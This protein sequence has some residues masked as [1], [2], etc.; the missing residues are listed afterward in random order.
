MSH[1]YFLSRV[2]RTTIEICNTRIRHVKVIVCCYVIE[3]YFQQLDAPPLH[4][5]P[6]L[7]QLATSIYL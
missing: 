1:Y 2:V 4:G 5:I 3:D 6:M 7:A